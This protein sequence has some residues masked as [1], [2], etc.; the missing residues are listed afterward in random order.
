MGDATQS[1][2]VTLPDG[3]TLGPVSAEQM[4]E[5][6]SRGQIPPNALV[7]RGDWPEPRLQSEFISE[8]AA[9][10]PSYL[11]QAVRNP[12]GTYFFG[13]KLREYE[14]QGDAISPVRRRRVFLRWVILLAVM[15][16]LAIVLPLA[17]GAI[18]GDWNLAG[19]GVLLA[20]F[21]A[22][23]PAF[24]FLFGMLMYAGAW[25]EWQWFFRSRTMRH[26]RGM[27]GDSGARSFYLIFGRV[28]MVGGAMFSLGSSLL[29][30]SGIMFG[31]A[32][33]RNAAGN[34]P[35]ARQRIRVAEQSVEQTRQ[36]FEQNARPLA[37]LARQMSDLRQRIER[38]PNDLKLREELTRVESRTPKLY[39]DYRLFRDQW[40]QQV[41]RLRV[42][43]DAEGADSNVLDENRETPP[44]LDFPES[45]VVAETD[46]FPVAEV[47]QATGKLANARRMVERI[48]AEP[49]GMPAAA[50]ARVL[51]DVAQQR[52]L[53][54][55]VEQ[56]FGFR[57]PELDAFP[58]P[59]QLATQIAQ[60]VDNRPSRLDNPNAVESVAD[61]RPSRSSTTEPPIAPSATPPRK[62]PGRGGVSL[63]ARFDPEAQTLKGHVTLEQS[64]N[65]PALITE[66]LAEHSLVYWNAPV[67][68][69]RYEIEA[70]ITRLEGDGALFLVLTF[71]G[72]AAALVLDGGDELGPRSGLVAVDRQVLSSPNYP[73]QLVT[74]KQFPTGQS[75]H[76]LCSVEGPRLKLH[77]NGQ[78]V[79]Q[80][81]DALGRLSLPPFYRSE[82]RARLHIGS[83]QSRFRIESLTVRLN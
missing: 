38:S 76:I 30:A 52:D 54:L 48:Q 8:S 28:L 61:S 56:R 34:G 39:A 64:T 26:A 77:I 5:A 14:R 29:I 50:R 59:E 75:V 4:H 1:W 17:S 37:E 79:Y 47:R 63:L 7:R 73:T 51:Q 11:Q 12:I 44:E 31:D 78:Q 65:G 15:P 82:H 36:L 22:L 66:S 58:A 80:W 3:R 83:F 24:F 68:P 33:P 57:S 40:R 55:S 53:L 70:D 25:F 32:G 19:G 43:V 67:L 69:P 9:S 20:L 60:R 41:E 6:A 18:R 23:W 2:F 42:A 74:G 81:E 13:P 71:P 49:N 62:P 35:P 72:R 27:F 21:A 16:L 46:R 45:L 10:E